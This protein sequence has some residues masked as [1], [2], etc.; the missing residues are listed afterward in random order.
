MFFLTE[1]DF[2]KKQD[3]IS[4]SIP[5]IF[6]NFLDKNFTDSEPINPPDPVMTTID[7]KF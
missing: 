5:I 6:E 7:I 4:L 1:A 2:P 3:L